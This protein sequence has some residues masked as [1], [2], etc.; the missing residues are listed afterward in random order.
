M[1]GS[2]GGKE[3]VTLSLFGSSYTVNLCG[4][5]ECNAAEGEQKWTFWRAPVNIS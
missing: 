3:R 5:F 2:E 4:S 1:S